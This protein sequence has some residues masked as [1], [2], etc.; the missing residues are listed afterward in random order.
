MKSRLRICFVSSYP[1]THARLS[2]Y[3]Q[4]LVQALA[5]RDT[6]GKIYV[7]ADT[8][9]GAK[10][11]ETVLNGKVEIQRV[12]QAD[13]PLS[14]IGVFWYILKLKPD[15]VHFN[16]HFQ[17]FGR[18]RLSNFC[19]FTLVGLAKMFRLR[20]VVLLH[21]LAERTDFEK[22]KM[23]RS[24][25]NSIGILLAMRLVTLASRIVTPV[26]CYAE[27][28]R[29][30]YHREGVVYIP[31]GCVV[32]EKNACSGEKDKVVLMFGHMGPSKGLPV[33]FAAF[34]Q[35]SKEKDGVRLVVAG[36]SHPNYPNYL[37]ELRS[38]APDGVEFL[39]YVK[40]ENIAEVFQ[41]ADV[42]A[43]P[44]LTAT[45][46]S[47][48][49]HLACGYGKSIVASNLPE[50]KELVSEGASAVLTC[51]GDVQGFKNAV[52]HVLQNDDVAQKMSWQN[53][54]FAKRESWSYV[55]QEYEKVYLSLLS[56][57]KN[58]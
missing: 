8:V 30:R 46:T 26:H 40:E 18:S 52:L 29:K 6:I 50:I 48:V 56:E 53:L 27:D 5:G 45:G 11:G 32:S 33:M 23:K 49:F 37:S 16:L 58:A 57:G 43:L 14:I 7:L 55:A 25:A 4:N 34:E 39:G 3:A 31:H 15:I 9:E 38:V 28:I 13:R 2:E 12:W 19:G 21:N 47:G 22:L 35:L 36:G 24:S 54:Q 41:N 20:S 44:Y 1:P 42:V 17:S 51:A 10:S